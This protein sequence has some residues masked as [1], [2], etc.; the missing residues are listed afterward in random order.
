M[1]WGQMSD[2]SWLSWTGWGR[3]SQ[4]MVFRSSVHRWLCR[5]HRGA[6]WGKTPGTI[7]H[8]QVFGWLIMLIRHSSFYYKSKKTELLYLMDWAWETVQLWYRGVRFRKSTAWFL[9][10]APT[11]AFWIF[12][13]SHRTSLLHFIHLLTSRFSSGGNV[14]CQE[15]SWQCL[16]TW[17]VSW[18]CGRG[19]TGF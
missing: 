19:A 14:A 15:D 1:V 7:R 16:G 12:L 9:I 18:G 5:N 4:G 11:P 2:F 3:C 13:G 10:P 8:G 6:P 17:L